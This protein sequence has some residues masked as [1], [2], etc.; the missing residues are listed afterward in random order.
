MVF[1]VMSLEVCEEKR[2]GQKN[3]HCRGG[4]RKSQPE[5]EK[6]QPEVEAHHNSVESGCQVIKEAKHTRTAWRLEAR[7]GHCFQE[8]ISSFSQCC[9]YITDEDG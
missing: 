3:E 1:K 4:M 5:A 6:G 2:G 7:G 8:G 9:C